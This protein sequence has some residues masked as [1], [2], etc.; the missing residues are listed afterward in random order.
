MAEQRLDGVEVGAVVEHVGGERVAKHMGTFP[1]R[2]YSVSDHGV[3][4]DVVHHL[5]VKRTA[6]VAHE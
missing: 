3:V 5:S 1:L 2:M 4:D 6:I